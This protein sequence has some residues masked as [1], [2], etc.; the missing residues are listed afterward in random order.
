M[1]RLSSLNSELARRL[2]PARDWYRQREPRE[3]LALRLLAAAL[4]LALLW[5]LLVQPLRQHYAASRND[6]LQQTRLLNWIEDNAAVIRQQQGSSQ[7]PVA[8]AG[9]DW[10]AQLSRSASANGVT[11]R[12]FNPEG[13]SAV[14]I[15]V[16]AQPFDNVMIWLQSLERDQGIRVAMAEFSSTSSSGMVNL[17]A[18]LKRLP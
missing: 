1:N 11:L 7:R 2:A 17:R 10:V 3:Q 8:A 14:R 5:L 13:D 18:T 12:G 15:Q 9:G 16:E 4:S 6:Y